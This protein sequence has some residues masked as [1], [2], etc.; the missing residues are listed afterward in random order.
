MNM[1]KY[2]YLKFPL[3]SMYL[4]ELL[5]ALLMVYN[6]VSI[7]MS[8]NCYSLRLEEIETIESE[9]EVN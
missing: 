9:S 4:A 6:T 1:S 2:T 5:N 8:D 3:D 7:Q